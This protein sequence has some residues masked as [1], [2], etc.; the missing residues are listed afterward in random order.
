MRGCHGTQVSCPVD[1]LAHLFLGFLV[2][3]TAFCT[4]QL[5]ADACLV[6]IGYVSAKDLVQ[7]ADF[8]DLIL[9][10]ASLFWRQ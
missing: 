3:L 8:I 2:C 4:L 10:F 7:T 5:E 9:E 1:N 6:D